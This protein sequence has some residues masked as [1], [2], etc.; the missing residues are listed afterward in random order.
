MTGVS[1]KL[2]KGGEVVAEDVTGMDGLFLLPVREEA[3]GILT[4]LVEKAGFRKVTESL[5]LVGG[6]Q[7]C[8]YLKLYPHEAPLSVRLSKYDPSLSA[9]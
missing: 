6:G 9:G 4:L 1:V 8:R 7:V 2:L 5:K 3:G